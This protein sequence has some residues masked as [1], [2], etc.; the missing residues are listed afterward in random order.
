M[1]IQRKTIYIAVFVLLAV[2]ILLSAYNYYRRLKQPIAP[3]INAIPADALMFAEFSNVIDLW[4]TNNASNIIW[5]NLQKLPFFATANSD[6][7]FINTLINSNPNIKNITNTNKSYLSLHC[8]GND[9]LALLYLINVPATFED[10]DIKNMLKESGIKDIKQQKFEGVLIYTAKSN[11]SAYHYCVYKGVFMGSYSMPLV[12]KGI[13]QLNNNTSIASDENF[14]NLQATAGK[15]VDANIY[16][17]YTNLSKWLALF[18][19]KE[20]TIDMTMLA[21]FGK[22]TEMDLFVK[23]N[24]LLLNGYT[25]AGKNNPSYISIFADEAAQEIQ[26]TNILPQNTL[27]FSDVIFSNYASYHNK[28]KNFLK[29]N[30][31]LQEYEKKLSNMNLQ[32]K[33]NLSDNFIEWMGKEFA[34]VVLQSETNFSDNTFVICQANDLKVA[35][36]CLK[37]IAKASQQ[38]NNE[39]ETSVVDA[40]KILLPDLLKTLLGGACPS[41]K[42]C[43]FE[44]ANDFVIFA[45]SKQAICN[46][47]NAFS[48]GEILA[49]SK[50]YAEY[51]ANIPSKS[52]IYAYI[53]LNLAANY[54]MNTMKATHTPAFGNIFPVLQGFQKLSFQLSAEDK[55]FYTTINFNFK[56]NNNIKPIEA[57]VV[58]QPISSGS[59]TTLDAP[60][61]NRPY[62]VKN[63]SSNDKSIIVFDASNKMYFMNK[64]GVIKWSV[65]LDGKPKSDVYEVDFLKNNKIQYLFNTENSI[66]LID[67]NG[68][69]IEGYPVKLSYKATSGLCLIDYEKKLDYRIAI[70]GIDRKIHYFN[71]KGVTVTDFKSPTTKDIVETTPQHIIFGGK[72]NIIITDRSGN[73]LILDR[74]GNERFKLKTNFAKNTISKCYYDGKYLITTDKYGKLQFISTNGTI[75][76]K[77]FK[78]ISGNPTFAYEDFNNDGTKDFIFLTPTELNIFKKDGKVIFNYK[79]NQAVVPILQFYANT[80][81]GNLIAIMGRDNK[82]LYIFNKTGLLDESITFKG[83]TMPDIASLFDKKHLNLITGSGNKL[84]K[85]TF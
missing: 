42:E 85:Y 11:A 15:K 25:T 1:K 56:G 82:Q 16:I 72:D 84:L 59:E 81:R 65:M 14:I 62:I 38:K 55:R 51:S 39:I 7:V 48:S 66:Y 33:L 32:V 30:E 41:F 53:N 80:Q 54:L 52:N 73:V 37:S 10:T 71:I 75:D 63:T 50:D 40:N 35:D 26:I 60:M 20:T 13:L 21:D 9:S 24:Q 74:K 27:L 46:Y 79:F 49:K 5:Q 3:V 36:S 22:W 43:W 8:L 18:I 70:A 83:E 17:N 67:A 64:E 28:Y 68:K 34:V 19:N 69:K 29:E 78:T 31:K 4:N 23:T 76:T 47:R 6:I 61:V 45:A 12:E 57:A 44:T 2:I 58:T 77:I